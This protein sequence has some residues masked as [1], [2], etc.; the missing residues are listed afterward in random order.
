MSELLMADSVALVR[1]KV[2]D[3]TLAMEDG[4]MNSVITLATI[5]VGLF[6]HTLR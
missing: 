6:R 4:T 1:R 2:Q 3:T 5:E